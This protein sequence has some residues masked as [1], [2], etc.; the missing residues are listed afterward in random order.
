[1][2]VKSIAGVLQYSAILSTFIKLLFVLKVIVLSIFEWPLK[3]GFTVLLN[4]AI[5]E[6]WFVSVDKLRAFSICSLFNYYSIVNIK[7]IRKIKLYLY[8][9]IYIHLYICER[10]MD[11]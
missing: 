1:M 2:Q 9:H 7:N 8:V 6:H 4:Q 3:T 5:L 10:F 11:I